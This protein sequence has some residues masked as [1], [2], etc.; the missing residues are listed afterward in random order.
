[1]YKRYVKM[2]YEPHAVWFC[3]HF[4]LTSPP[5]MKKLV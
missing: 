2:P 5:F 1:V 3:R 4:K